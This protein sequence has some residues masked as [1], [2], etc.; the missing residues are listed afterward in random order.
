MKRLLLFTENFPFGRGEEFL[1][2]EIGYYRAVFDSI[3]LIPASLADGTIRPLP[4]GVAIVT[5]F[6][7]LLS[8]A[9]RFTRGVQAVRFPG[10]LREIIKNVPLSLSRRGLQR[11]YAFAWKGRLLA[12]WL[13]AYLRRKNFDPEACVFFAY[14]LVGAVTGLSLVPSV[15]QSGRFVALAHGYDLYEQRND[16]P[17]FPFRERTI[18]K[19]HQVFVISRHG[20]RHLQARHPGDAAKFSHTPRGTVDP[21]KLADF[22]E[23]GKLRI[24][25]CSFMVPVKRVHL[26]A[27]ALRLAGKECPAEK[28]I[29]W[30]HIGDGPLRRELEDGCRLFSGKVMWRFLGYVPQPQVMDFYR[31]NPVDVFMN[32]SSHEGIPTSVMESQSC[33]VPVMA[34]AVGGTPEIVNPENGWL[35]PENPSA[36]EIADILLGLLQNK[37]ALLEK[38]KLSRKNWEHFYNA[39]KNSPALVKA[40]AGCS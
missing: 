2:E 20:L 27:E 31:E 22:S 25:S 3:H 38:R 21:G 14:W 16:P 37:K 35:L 15:Y 12:G 11:I 19:L 8:G 9:S 23:D 39:D 10:L 18:R 5:E 34:T 32:V 4:A 28:Q 7:D 6:A 1:E 33:G 29:V 30:T 36:R 13:P 24:V 40:V 17:F 26:L